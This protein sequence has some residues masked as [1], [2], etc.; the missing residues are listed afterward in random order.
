MRNVVELQQCHHRDTEQPA[1]KTVS[2]SGTTELPTTAPDSV[3]SE[4]REEVELDLPAGFKILCS[5]CDK[6]PRGFRGET[7]LRRHYE[8]EHSAKRQVWICKDISV[9][10]NFLSKCKSCSEKKQYNADYNAIEHLRRIHFPEDVTI[11]V[12]LDGEAQ[13][14]TFSRKNEK[15]D[16]EKWLEPME[17]INPH[18]RSK[19]S[20]SMS[21][22]PD[23]ESGI[24]Y[25][26]TWKQV[27]EHVRQSY[28]SAGNANKEADDWIERPG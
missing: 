26:K 11:G 16:L 24:N 1:T 17:Y 23:V 8:R 12:Q 19:A 21:R 13:T 6:F 27:K 3:T 7:E 2:R 20:S 5:K 14:Q 15:Q 25:I 9:R 4:T 28:G 18:E 22:L 10:G